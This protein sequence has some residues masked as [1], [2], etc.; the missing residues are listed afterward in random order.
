MKRLQ[1]HVVNTKQTKE[2]TII[3]LT[4]GQIA[5]QAGLSNDTVRLYE[6][7]GLIKKPERAP[8]GYRQYSGQAI[9]QLQFISRAKEM[10]FTLKEIKE[11]LSIHQTS[12]HTCGDVKHRT[13]EKLNQLAEKIN[14]LKKLESAIKQ[15]QADCDKHKPDDL[16]PLF[17][18]LKQLEKTNEKH[19]KNQ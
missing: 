19:T 6:R 17:T 2:Q 1:G 14:E 18:A 16:C 12:Q 9:E 13:Q 5:K 7:Y 10:G 4:I 15:L 3:L 8:N 11:L